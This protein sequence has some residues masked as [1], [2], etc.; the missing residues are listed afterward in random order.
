MTE[1]INLDRYQKLNYLG[2][3]KLL[4]KHDKKTNVEAKQWFMLRVEDS[5]F[6]KKDI[7]HILVQV[8]ET[9]KII[10]S[11]R[12]KKVVEER[13]GGE[14]GGTSQVFERKTTKYWVPISNVL[15]VKCMI[16]KHLPIDIFDKSTI[17]SD[18]LTTSVYY[19]SPDLVLYHDRLQRNE[20]AVNLRMRSYGKGTKQPIIFVE[21]KTH[22]DSWYVI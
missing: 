3:N 16:I 22:H 9:W 18:N 2:F 15:E 20:G 19:D 6:F 14:V 5:P 4:K 10:L 11:Q 17:R 13:K 7:D 1:M 21:R 12:N 8:S